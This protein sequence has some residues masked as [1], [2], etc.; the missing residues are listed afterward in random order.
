MIDLNAE[1]GAG[2]GV[3]VDVNIGDIHG[4]NARNNEFNYEIN[5]GDGYDVE[6][7]SGY[8]LGIDINAGN[9]GSLGIDIN[10]GTEQGIVN[11]FNMKRKKSNV[12]RK[13]RE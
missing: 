6:A 9:K 7:K 11:Y 12:H 5:A 2:L 13:S 3:N 4:G 10:V 8:G 1:F